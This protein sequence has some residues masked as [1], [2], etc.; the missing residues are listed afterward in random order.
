MNYSINEI[1]EILGISQRLFELGIR[2]PF[3]KIDQIKKEQEE[4]YYRARHSDKHYFKPS[5]DNSRFCSRCGEYFT[6]K[7]HVTD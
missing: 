1:K 6:D 7:I 2:D 5:D 4:D 3:K